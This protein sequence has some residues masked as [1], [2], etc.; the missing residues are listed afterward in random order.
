[1]TVVKVPNTPDTEPVVKI[2]A[3]DADPT[4]FRKVPESRLPFTCADFTVKKEPK[5][6]ETDPV[7]KRFVT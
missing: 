4:T 6:P 3:T 1:M 7:V 5:V 2:P